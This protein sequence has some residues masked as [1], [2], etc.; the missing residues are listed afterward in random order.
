MDPN[1]ADHLMM[2]RRHDK[3]PGML[4]SVAL[5]IACTM[6]MVVNVSQ[7]YCVLG[8][9]D[10]ARQLSNST[11][12]SIALPIIGRELNIMPA[13]LQWLVWSK[14]HLVAHI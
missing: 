9:S 14:R 7:L 12:V 1:S 3:A 13:R 11:S 8:G 5:I 10:D 2:S 6:A 4:K